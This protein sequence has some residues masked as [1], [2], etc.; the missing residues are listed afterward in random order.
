VVS[1]SDY[2]GF[3][4]TL[5]EAMAGGRPFVSWESGAAPEMAATGGGCLVRSTDEFVEALRRLED[6]AARTEMGAIGR[7]AAPDWSVDAM[8]DRY[9]A[10][11]RQLL[12]PR[13]A[14]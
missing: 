7:A 12:G 14:P 13:P 10:L 6:S 11:Y 3:G 9:L 2:E 4:V 8:T 1:A 5:A